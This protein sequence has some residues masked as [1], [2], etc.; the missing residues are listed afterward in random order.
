VEVDQ[1]S[2]HIEQEQTIPEALSTG[3]I[4]L[5]N[6]KTTIAFGLGNYR[7][8][9]YCGKIIHETVVD[10]VSESNV[11][12]NLVSMSDHKEVLSYLTK[13]QKKG[14]RVIMV[15]IPRPAATDQVLHRGAKEQAFLGLMNQ[16][17]QRYQMEYWSYPA[18][19]P[20]TYFYDLGHLNQ[21]GRLLY[22]QWLYTKLE[23]E[24]Q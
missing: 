11:N 3:A 15:Q 20:Y 2:Y 14:V 4:F 1:L 21:R 7:M 19:L 6:L 8:P 12:W 10:S 22:S 24:I 18:L 23:K 17:K 16:Y 9:E 5:K 13:L